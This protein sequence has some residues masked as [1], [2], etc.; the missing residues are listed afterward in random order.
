MGGCL[1]IAVQR[2]RYMISVRH[3]LTYEGKT[4]Q[5]GAY[6]I[7]PRS[8]GEDPLECPRAMRVQTNYDYLDIGTLLTQ[9]SIA[10][11]FV[12]ELVIKKLGQVS[13][14][15]RVDVREF[16][17]NERR[18]DG[19]FVALYSNVMTRGRQRLLYF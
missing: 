8:N 12:E 4:W 1:E 10:R 6:R 7:R 19:D 16:I 2:T 9:A 5:P 13:I 18:G 15:D 3:F 17:V 14:C 11:P